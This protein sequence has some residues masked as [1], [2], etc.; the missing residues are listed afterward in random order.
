MT[1]T[2]G[3]GSSHRL[4]LPDVNHLVELD[5][6]QTLPQ[7]WTRYFLLAPPLVRVSNLPVVI[8]SLSDA[9]YRLGSASLTGS[10]ASYL[11][12]LVPL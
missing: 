3:L 6:G 1:C 11:L 7:S 10:L 12:T 4:R 2:H 9:G 5:K 8:G